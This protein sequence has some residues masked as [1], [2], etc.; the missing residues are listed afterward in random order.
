VGSIVIRW[1][2]GSSSHLVVGQNRRVHF[3][4]RRGQLRITVIVSDR[5]G[6]V[7]R[8]GQQITIS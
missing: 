1:G 5:A 6:N 8:Q 2:D 7:T 4:R 3:Y